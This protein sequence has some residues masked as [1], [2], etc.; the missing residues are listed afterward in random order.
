MLVDVVVGA[1][2]TFSSTEVPPIWRREKKREEVGK[3]IYR[4][5]LYD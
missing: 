4:E 2:D 1:A 3:R 5:R